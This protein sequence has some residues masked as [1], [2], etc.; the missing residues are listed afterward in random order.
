MDISGIMNHTN[1]TQIEN[2][3]TDY[4]ENMRYYNR[5]MRELIEIYRTSVNDEMLRRRQRQ[6]RFYTRNYNSDSFI[7]T[8]RD[9]NRFTNPSLDLLNPLAPAN[10]FTTQLQDVVVYP[11]HAQIE[12]A[13]E[14]VVYDS[15]LAQFQCP[16][17]LE[18]FEEGVEICRIKHCRHLFKRASLISWFQRNVRCPVCRYDIRDYVEES[19]ESDP[20]SEEEETTTNNTRSR[21]PTTTNS[22]SN[23][24]RTFS[25]ITQGSISNFLRNLLTSEINQ[26]LPMINE[27]SFTF[28]L[29]ADYDV[30]YNSE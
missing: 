28:D 26:T 5:N 25:N 11:T 12:N 20:E 29:P 4:N 6:Q 2:M 1:L 3:I 8:P 7:Y 18:P 13:V 22:S 15:S 27:L 21:N 24:V 9:L 16:I 10:W 17:S 19:N 30:S 14:N 23:N